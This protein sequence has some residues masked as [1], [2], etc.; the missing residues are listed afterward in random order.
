[1][2]TSDLHARLLTTGLY[3]LLQFYSTAPDAG[4][5]QRRNITTIRR[6]QANLSLKPNKT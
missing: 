3:V 5:I 2:D 6:L 4:S 1:L